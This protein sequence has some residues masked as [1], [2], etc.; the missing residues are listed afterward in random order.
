VK[1]PESVNPFASQTELMAWLFGSLSAAYNMLA[2]YERDER[3]AERKRIEEIFS[4]KRPEKTA[5]A[6]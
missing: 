5:E 4:D 2:Q 6:S 3:K 1:Y